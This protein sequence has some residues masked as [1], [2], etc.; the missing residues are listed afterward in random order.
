MN[1]PGS[2]LPSRPPLLSLPDVNECEMSLCGEAPCENFD[3]SFLCICP[4]DNEEFDTIT[5]QCR[6]A[7]NGTGLELT[8]THGELIPLP[9]IQRRSCA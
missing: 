7:G 6:S 2:L 5:S 8:V 4:N 1:A 3:G 9:V